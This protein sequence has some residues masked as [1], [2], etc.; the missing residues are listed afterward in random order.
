MTVQ[1]LIEELSGYDPELEVKI[2]ST[3]DKSHDIS[4]VW[5]W[6]NSDPDGDQVLN[7]YLTIEPITN[8]IEKI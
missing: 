1:E 5:Q 3:N 4:H 6:D 2:G 7:T 8:K